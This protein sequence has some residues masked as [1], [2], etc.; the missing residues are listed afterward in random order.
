M[1]IEAKL[2]ST[3]KEGDQLKLY[4]VRQNLHALS[5]ALFVYA[6]SYLQLTEL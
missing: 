1:Q 6:I 3:V 4:Q 5:Q 2:T